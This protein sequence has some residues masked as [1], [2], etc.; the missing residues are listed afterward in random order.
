VDSTTNGN[1]VSSIAFGNGTFVLGAWG[2]AMAY[3]TDNGKSWTAVDCKL[4]KSS[5]VAG[6]AFGN[7]KFVAGAYDDTS[8]STDNGKTWTRVSDIGIVIGAI[9]Y[10]NNTFVAVGS[11][12]RI[13]YSK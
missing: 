1:N 4:D 10:G 12:G 9:A 3:S 11:S 6:I 13:A 2:G 8:Y 7:G 5:A